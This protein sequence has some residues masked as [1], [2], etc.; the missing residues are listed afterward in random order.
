MEMLTNL[1]ILRL[2]HNQL[3]VL[4]EAIGELGNLESLSG[5]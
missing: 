4:P 3:D 2:S 5:E 1:R